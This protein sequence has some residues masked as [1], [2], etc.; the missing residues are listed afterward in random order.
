MAYIDG[1][2]ILFSSNYTH[3][4]GAYEIA[5]GIG[6]DEAQV[7]SQKAVTR[8]FKSIVSNIDA[9]LND[10]IISRLIE[11]TNESVT[12]SGETY[13]ASTRLLSNFFEVK[14]NAKYI[15]NNT[16]SA[17]IEYLF[18]DESKN[19]ITYTDWNPPHFYTRSNYK[20]V[21]LLVKNNTN[22]DINPANYEHNNWLT[23]RLADINRRDYDLENLTWEN[24]TINESNGTLSNAGTRCTSELIPIHEDDIIFVLKDKTDSL[25]YQ[26]HFYH[27]DGSC[28]VANYYTHVDRNYA[29][30]HGCVGIRLQFRKSDNTDMPNMSEFLTTVGN[31]TCYTIRDNS[32]LKKSTKHELTVAHQNIRVFN[33]SGGTKG[34]PNNEVD[35]NLPRWKANIIKWLNADILNIDEWHNKFDQSGNID[36][37]AELLKQF[38]PYYYDTGNGKALFS[39]Y[40]CTF[41]EI[42]ID[43]RLIV[44]DFVAEGERVAVVGWISSNTYTPERRIT[45]YNA[46]IK[47]LSRYDKAVILGDFNNDEGAAELQVFT[48]NG[49][50]LGNNGYWGE[51]DTCPSS[52]PFNAIDNII[53]KG[54]IFEDFAVGDD[55]VT[56]DHYPIKARLTFT[57]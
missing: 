36:A 27:E 53:T 21:R 26:V 55:K 42:F 34:C 18:Y 20:Y 29:I 57:V 12:N 48:E 50:T 10:N 43:Q 3:V 1:T 14:D 6:D 7:M 56:S 41:N 24:K 23:V 51:I 37:Y 13:S 19:L 47:Y 52:N 49:Y 5:Q 28:S 2:E 16:K 25:W 15:V 22:T 4:E 38:Y 8:G 39:K 32:D 17:L 11:F 35:A 40:P 54:F 46:L 45:A 44:C 33:Y 31:Y 9:L 30:P